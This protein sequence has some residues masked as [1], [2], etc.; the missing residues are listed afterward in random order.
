MKV[1]LQN[2]IEKICILYHYR[3]VPANK[4][5]HVSKWACRCYICFTMDMDLIDVLLSKYLLRYFSLCSRNF[6]NVELRLD[7]DEIWSFYR[8]SDFTWNQILMNSNGPKMLI[9]TILKFLN[10]DFCK[11]EQLS[12]PK[13][14]KILSSESLKLPK[15]TFL[16]VWICQKWFHV[17]SEWR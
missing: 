5:L 11:F 17:K 12:S 2:T 4:R 8:L 15:K 3:S 13:L 16:I 10:F 1:R 14:T 6:Q 7:F 9:L